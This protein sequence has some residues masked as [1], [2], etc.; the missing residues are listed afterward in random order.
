MQLLVSK[1]EIF[2]NYL[3]VY[4]FESQEDA[5]SSEIGFTFRKG[6]ATCREE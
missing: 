4:R 1:P 3:Q 6:T 2:P 5:F